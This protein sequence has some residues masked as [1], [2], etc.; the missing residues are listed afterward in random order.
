MRPLNWS[1][2]GPAHRT[3]VR[4]R[5]GA[6]LVLLNP[7]R[8]MMACHGSGVNCIVVLVCGYNGKDLEEQAQMIGSKWKKGNSESLASIC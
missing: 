4:R 5:L 7:Q 6:E 8:L 2:R 3:S 1:G